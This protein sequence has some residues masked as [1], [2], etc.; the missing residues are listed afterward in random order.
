LTI[1]NPVTILAAVIPGHARREAARMA[2][3]WTAAAKAD[4]RLAEDLIR[5]GNV[6]AGQPAVL[7]NGLPTPDLPDAQL[8]AYQAGRRD[9]ALQVLALMNLTPTQLN[10]LVQEP[11]YEPPAY[12]HD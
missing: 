9:M 11:D 2:R 12:D 1:W 8:L 6:L 5:L 4:P 7:D 10:A 3:R